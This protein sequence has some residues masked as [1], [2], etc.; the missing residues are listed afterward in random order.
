[1]INWAFGLSTELM[2]KGPLLKDSS[3]DV[4]SISPKSDA[5]T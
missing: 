4:S 5:L 3:A 1:M 2:T